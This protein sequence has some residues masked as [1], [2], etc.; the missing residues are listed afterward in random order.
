[1]RP[2]TQKATTVILERSMKLPV[3]RLHHQV[4]VTCLTQ[5]LSWC[6]QQGVIGTRMRLMA[7]GTTVCSGL[8]HGSAWPSN[9]L[10]IVAIA[11]Q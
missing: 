2:M 11:A 1:M 10:N 4:L 8:V 3:I 7:T 5:R 6:E 9:L